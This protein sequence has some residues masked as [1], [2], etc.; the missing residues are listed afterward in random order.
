LVSLHNVTRL[1][2][3][4]TSSNCFAHKIIDEQDTLT[5]QMLTLRLILSDKELFLLCA[6]HRRARD[7]GRLTLSMCA[8][9]LPKHHGDNVKR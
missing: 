1:L 8:P 5:L 3:T 2:N 6:D 9:W 4:P 7:N